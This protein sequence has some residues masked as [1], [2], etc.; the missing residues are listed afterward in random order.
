MEVD[1]VKIGLFTPRTRIPIYLRSVL[2]ETARLLSGD[3]LKFSR[4]FVGKYSDDLGGGGKFI[5]PHTEVRVVDH[6]F[7]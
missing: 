5:V 2:E 3:F 6:T 7:H 4:I 1:R